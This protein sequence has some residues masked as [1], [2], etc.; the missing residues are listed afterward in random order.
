ME[1]EITWERAVRVW[2]SYLWRAILM[3]LVAMVIAGLMGAILSA[4]MGAM[5]MTASAIQAVVFMLGAVI[6]LGVS[7][8]PMK[9]I[10]GKDFG[11]YRL[12]LVAKSGG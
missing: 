10:L 7:I 9:L 6:G 11:Q 5:G 3:T 1:L 8:V 4:F 12:V 2:W